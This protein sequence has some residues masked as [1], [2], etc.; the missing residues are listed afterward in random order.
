[1]R[2]RLE[3]LL[4]KKMELALSVQNLDRIVA[5]VLRRPQ[6]A[7]PVQRDRGLGNGLLERVEV[8]GHQVNVVPAEFL[9]F[10]AVSGRGAGVNGE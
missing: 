3:I 7:P 4:Q 10:G 1:M 8:D 9:Q 2:Q 5:V 6:D